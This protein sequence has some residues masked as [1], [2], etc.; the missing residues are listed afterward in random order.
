MIHALISQNSNI[1]ILIS[2]PDDVPEPPADFLL[3]ADAQDFLLLADGT[4]R[5]KLGQ[6]PPT[7]GY[8]LLLADGSSIL[9]LAD[10]TSKMELG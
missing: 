1:N 3:L 10:G 6:N 9:L 8:F 7:A 2:I 4:S 5:L